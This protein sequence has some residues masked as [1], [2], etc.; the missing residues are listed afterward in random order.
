MLVA[1]TARHLQNRKQNRIKKIREEQKSIQAEFDS[2]KNNL[3]ELT[4]QKNELQSRLA[5]AKTRKISD[6][7]KEEE[8]KEQKSTVDILKE[9][10]QITEAQLKKATH[11][12]EENQ[13]NLELQD[14]LV[15]FGYITPEQLKKA[16][17][18]KD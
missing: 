11:Y 17:D 3:H 8:A 7:Q 12:L 16:Q 14:V 1:F 10:E 18:K 2:L 13:P 6:S 15:M 5:E 9:N 4:A